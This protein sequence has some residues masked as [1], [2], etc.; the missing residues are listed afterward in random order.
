MEEQEVPVRAFDRY[1]AFEG[2]PHSLA[3]W[4]LSIHKNCDR[5][6]GAVLVFS[7]F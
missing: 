7:R 6:G 3:T 5:L 4:N 1:D 2:H